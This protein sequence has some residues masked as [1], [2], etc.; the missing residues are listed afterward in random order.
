ML[1]TVID[2]TFSIALFINA[3]LFVPQA[4]RIVKEKSAQS[5]SM[6]TF[7]G[8]LL[9]QGATIVHATLI[10]DKIL[11]L[12]YLFSLI[13]CGTV[14]ILALFYRQNKRDELSV[15]PR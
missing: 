10:H 13:T 3:L 15:R 9:V 5:I 1:E 7:S 14:V 11:F 8:F 6:I 2:F 12:G 4:I